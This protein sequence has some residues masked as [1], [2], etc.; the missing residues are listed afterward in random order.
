MRSYGTKISGLILSFLMVLL[1]FAVAQ[2]AVP[3]KI[4]MVGTT[5]LK[6]IFPGGNNIAYTSATEFAVA[7]G[8]DFSITNDSVIFIQGGRTIRLVYDES[9]AAA[10]QYTKALEI[11]GIKSKGQAAGRSTNTVVVPVKVVA[12]AAGATV[13]DSAN[14]IDV[15]TDPAVLKGVGKETGLTS[16]R[17]AISVSRDVGFTARVEGNDLVVY[18]RNTVGENNPWE[19]GGK[20]IDVLNINTVGNKVEIRTK[21]AETVGYNVY[22]IAASEGVDGQPIPARVVIDVGTRYERVKTALD[23]QPLTVVL[24]PGH[25]GDDLGVVIDTLKEK[26]LSLRFSELV[27]KLLTSKGINVK[28]TRT[29]DSN[30]SLEERREMSLTSDVFLSFHVSNLPGSSV[31]GVQ[32]YHVG[33]VSPDGIVKGAREALEKETNPSDKRHLEAFVAPS[34]A[35]GVL[36][37][38]ISSN[39]MTNPNLFATV[40]SGQSQVVLERASKAACLIELGFVSDVKDRARLE[41]QIELKKLSLTV[42]RGVMAYLAPQLAKKALKKP[43]VKPTGNK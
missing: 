18:L 25:G 17:V 15:L 19:V 4:L 8:I 37:E 35:S 7:L 10:A 33:A 31:S 6:A 39:V 29:N 34:N 24:D 22:A 11:N 21:L 36:A 32:V 43:A 1:A 16:D 5:K 40:L 23:S 14:Q 27:G 3:S 30:P 38:A 9:A 20:Y 13:S 2:N 41:D 42:M 26:D 28:Y 12:E